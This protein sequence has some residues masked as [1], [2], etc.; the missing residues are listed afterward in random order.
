[1]PKLPARLLTFFFVLLAWVPFRATNWNQ[2]EQLYKAMFLPGSF[3]LPEI[4]TFDLCLFL[5]GIFIII[6]LKPASELAK[7]F[8][9][10]WIN[11]LTAAI[12]MIV[13]MFFFVKTSP[14][15]YFNF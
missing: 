8:R 15:I 6:F 2:A 9:P 1:M 5:A 14:F 4:S 11:A 7:K 13:S 3:A 10:T 12:L